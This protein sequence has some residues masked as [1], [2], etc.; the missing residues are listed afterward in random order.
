MCSCRSILECCV[1]FPGVK[2]SI[3]SF[4][5]FMF[6]SPIKWH[7]RRKEIVSGGGGMTKKFF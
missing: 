5:L 6:Y 2:L 1:T 4:V 7:Y 3:R